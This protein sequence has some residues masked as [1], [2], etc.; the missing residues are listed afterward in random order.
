[1]LKLRSNNLD[2]RSQAIIVVD[3]SNNGKK[4]TATM[5]K[6]ISLIAIAFLLNLSAS[7]QTKSFDKLDFLIGEWNG[8][9]SGFGKDKSKIVSKFLMAMDNKYIEVVNDSRFDPTPNNPTGEHHIDKGFISYDGSRKLIVFRQFNIEG[10]IN[11]YVLVDSL[12][13]DKIETVF[14]VYFPNKGY[15]CMRT[16]ILIKK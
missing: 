1:M 6:T 14:D 2:Y 8:T 9:G 5:T 10:Y 16:N 15:T 13:N 11:Q 7:A 3:L 4:K 12:S